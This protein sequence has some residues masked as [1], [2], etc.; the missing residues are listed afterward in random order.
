L[1]NFKNRLK[2]IYDITA[3]ADIEAEEEGSVI[4]LVRVPANPQQDGEVLSLA[5]LK[6]LEYRIYRKLREKL[7]N[8]A[9]KD[10]K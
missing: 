6:T 3:E 7:R 2:K 4:Y 5:K 9:S 8:F 10:N 1:I